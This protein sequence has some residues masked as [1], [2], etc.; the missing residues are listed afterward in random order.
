MNSLIVAGAAPNSGNLGVNA[1][2]NSLVSGLYPLVSATHE[3][4][5]LDFGTG[6]R[7]QA[8]QCGIDMGCDLIGANRSRRYYSQ[9]TFANVEWQ[10]RLNAAFTPTAKA[11]KNS[12][13]LDV[14]G[15]DS[16]TD[17]Y[18]RER[19]ELISYPKRI[20]QLYGQPLV[21]MPQ[22][23]G[24]FSDPS[25]REEAKRY[26]A[27]ARLIYT[28]DSRSMAYLRNLMGPEFDPSK[29]QEGVDMAFLLPTIDPPSDWVMET[30]K[31]N[32][33][34]INISGLIYND[35]VQAKAQ[36]GIKLDYRAAMLKLV[37]RLVREFDVSISLVPHVLVPKN[38]IESDA[39]ACET[40]REQLASDVKVRVEVLPDTLNESEVKGYI[41][42]F[43]WF[44]GM[45]MHAT[46]ASLSSAVPTV[47][48]AYSGK[49][50]GVFETV[51]QG[52]SVLDAR[53]L[54]QDDLVSGALA[55]YQNRTII[56]DRLHHRLQS[57]QSRAHSQMN[58]IAET[59]GVNNETL[60]VCS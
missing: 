13:V 37:T 1:L 57:V 31:H 32:R 34:G 56:A 17:L 9:S 24:P 58:D 27:Y 51:E 23:I 2:C 22:T 54:N 42:Q 35:P 53:K 12:A 59:L 30:K 40:L 4:K 48:F 52:A 38:N 55:H 26:L 44:A 5:V 18:G 47:N 11:F 20:A 6:I 8:Y 14:S 10:A 21:L 16:F 39:R 7:R 33:V 45:R 28:R 50:L 41:G 29:C 3:I 60:T 25:V 46:I 15:G 36:Y 19:F 43:D 49:A